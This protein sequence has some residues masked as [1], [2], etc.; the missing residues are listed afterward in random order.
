MNIIHSTLVIAES[1]VEFSVLYQ[2]G[3][4]PLLQI[5]IGKTMKELMMPIGQIYPD[6]GSAGN[7][8]E[9]YRYCLHQDP[10]P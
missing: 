2:Y 10:A 5:R 9:W 3:T 7:L 6:S 1:R 4:V 8:N